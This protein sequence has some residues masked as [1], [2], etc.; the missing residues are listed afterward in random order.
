MDLKDAH[1][2][3]HGKTLEQILTDLVEVLGW[4]KM[5]EKIPIRCFEFEPSIK[6]SLTFLRKTPWARSKVETM[7]VF[8]YK[9]VL[10]KQQEK[11][12]D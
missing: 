4:E 5:A 12:S 3:L 6:S 10:R 9:K 1:T 2:I 11:Q 7:Y 8:N